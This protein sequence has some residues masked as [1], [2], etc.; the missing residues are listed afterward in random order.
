MMIQIPDE[1]TAMTFHALI[2]G[3]GYAA[4]AAVG[5]GL[6]AVSI[7]GWLIIC[8]LVSVHRS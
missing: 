7:V 4:L 2:V 3:L 5:V 8:A 1:G 6:I